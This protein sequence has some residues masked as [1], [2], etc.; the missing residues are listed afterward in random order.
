M[1][2]SR[3]PDLCLAVCQRRESAFSER[4]RHYEVKKRGL[5]PP[6]ILGCY[7]NYDTKL[8]A[9]LHFFDISSFIRLDF[10]ESGFSFEFGGGH[11]PLPPSCYTTLLGKGD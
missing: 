3:L 2:R 5:S 7:C 11:I 8:E 1:R 6:V 10:L 9:K 4:S